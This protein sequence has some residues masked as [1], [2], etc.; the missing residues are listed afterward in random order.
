MLARP[1]IFR[2]HTFLL[3]IERRELRDA[4]QHVA[5]GPKAFDVLCF[6]L[7]HR[8][9]LVTKAEL[10]DTFWSAQ[11][12][13]AALQKTISLIRKALARGGDRPDILRTHHGLG[14]RFVAEV[15]PE[16]PTG[17]DA[18]PHAEQTA[19]LREQRMITALSVRYHSGDVGWTAQT[20]AAAKSVIA[21]A[22]DIVARFDGR[23]LRMGT[24]GFSVSFGLDVI[25]EDGPRRAAH[26][27]LELR[28]AG[29]NAALP[30]GVGIDTGPAPS[31]EAQDATPWQ[32]PGAVERQAAALAGRANTGEILLSTAARDQLR[33]EAQ[34]SRSGGAH[35]LL[36]LN[37]MQSGVP[38]RPQRDAAGF[39]G[40]EAE[41]A[42]L[43]ASHAR[44]L[45]GSGQAVVL[46]GPAGIGKSRLL[47]EFLLQVGDA[48]GWSLTLQCLPARRNTP[49]A[50][51][52]DLCR[53]LFAVAPDGIL[54]D[55]IDAALLRDLRDHDPSAEAVLKTLSDHQRR[56]R[57]FALLNRMLAARCEAQPLLL[58]VED[59]HWI[60]ATSQACL[61]AILQDLGDK[62]L[63]VVMT[64]RPTEMPTLAEG[65]LHLPPL[66]TADSLA[67][68]RRTVGAA[69]LDESGADHLV[70]RAG[71][72]PFFI[73]ELALAAQSGGNPATDLPDTVQAV[74]SVRLGTLEPRSRAVAFAVAVVGPGASQVLIEAITGCAPDA[75]AALLEGLLRAGVLR[76]EGEG[77]GFRHML[78]QDAA[79]AMILPEERAG[80]HRKIAQLLQ[81]DG[82][83]LDARPETLA[84]HHQ[85]GGQPDQALTHWTRASRDA[86]RRS[87]RAE[88][89]AFA[90]NGL[91]LIDADTPQAGQRELELQL[92]LAPALA[93]LRGYAASDVGAAY[94]RARVLNAD[95][96]DLKSDI[97][98]LVGLW[99][100]S[101]VRGELDEALRFARK[102]NAIAA[103]LDDPALTVQ[104]EASLGQVLLHQGKTELAQKHLAAGL[105]CVENAPPTTLPAQNSAVACAS[106]AAWAAS[107]MGRTE[108]ALAHIETSERLSQQF[109]NP[110]AR[111][112]HFALCSEPHMF[113]GDA[114]GCLRLADRAV[115]ISR[116]H[117]FAFWL[118]TGLVMRGWAL[119]RA[120]ASEAA[121]AAFDEGITVFEA[122]G[123]G[124]QLANWYG[125]RAEAHLSAGEVEA[126]ISAATHALTCAEAAGDLFFTP[127]IHATLAALHAGGGAVE[128]AQKHR[129]MGQALV[130]DFC[131]S[132]R[133]LSVGRV[134]AAV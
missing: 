98:S 87:A 75:V 23:L 58:A 11:V 91:A 7:E 92:C 124:V 51:I 88:A 113:L 35:C 28:A 3:D 55:E 122:T 78:I 100:Y 72:N 130:R 64:T 131:I 40:R 85:Q 26:C 71:G 41:M 120:G 30:L 118:G 112:I 5:L 62:R 24:D 1:M 12:S 19:V 27:A 43:N 29:D 36:N 67:L 31:G 39:V 80:L 121:E 134:P 4:Q 45:R 93:A 33:D 68:L 25:C 22:Q 97:R 48:P 90:R 111:A 53:A 61:D 79:Y 101:W 102:L 117:D 21:A 8:D 104:A 56:Q 65:V 77:Y 66:G 60:D 6:L 105:A 74:I 99:I 84:W 54:R 126:G 132:E 107:L 73:E 70:G 14:F 133:F 59:T 34:T 57:G 128:T 47:A 95:I 20:E 114:A 42:F 15:T 125:L 63:L 46:S 115:D 109:D 106:Y 50:L 49:G 123:A 127:R 10:L 32:T 89:I 94:R 76:G 110:F 108:E 81:D 96:G 86:L 13:E 69:V 129:Q 119:G 37:S 9:R 18:P 116:E 44:A 16:Q 2:F 17:P 83:L 82:L 38:A 103:R 52:G